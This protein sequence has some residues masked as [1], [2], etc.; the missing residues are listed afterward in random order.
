MYIIYNISMLAFMFLV[1]RNVCMHDK[2]QQVA[3]CHRNAVWVLWVE[4][5]AG[6]SLNCLAFSAVILKEWELPVEQ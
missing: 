5:V 1:L 4:T 6:N 3:G 2:S